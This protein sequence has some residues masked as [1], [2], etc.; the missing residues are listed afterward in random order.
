MIKYRCLSAGG[1]LNLIKSSVIKTSNLKYILIIAFCSFI[2]YSCGSSDGSNIKTDDPDKA[3]FIAKSHY[4]KADYL[5]AIDDFNLIKLKFSGTSVIDKAVY[6]LGMSY[7]RRQEY[8]LAVYEFES[9]I[10]NYPT[11][12]F[13]EEARYQLAMCYYGLSPQYNLDQSYTKY[14]ITEF[15]NF[16]DI[17]PKSRYAGESDRRINELKNKLALKALKSAELY[18]NLGNYKSAIVYYDDILDEYFE[19]QYADDALYGKI[20]ALISK[21]K[22]EDADNEISRFEEKFSTSE[23]LPK[24]LA[25]KKQIP[26]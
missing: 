17:Y 8:I 22:Y 7:Y 23:Y 4:D 2:L 1:G 26:F 19:T 12:S 9:L 13:A 25:L 11:S 24:V 21:K 15:Q 16:L 3:Y 18:Y 5:D 14:A 10:K 20:Q 6:Y